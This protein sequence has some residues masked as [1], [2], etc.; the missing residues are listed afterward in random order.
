LEIKEVMMT[1]YYDVFI[2]SG[3]GLI[4]TYIIIYVLKRMM[5]KGAT[6]GLRG[7]AKKKAI[8]QTKS[9]FNFI[10][11][12]VGGLWAV[13]IAIMI[14]FHGWNIEEPHT[15]VE[16]LTK[17]DIKHIK[18]PTFKE[19]QEANVKVVAD[20]EQ[21]RQDHIDDQKQQARDEFDKFLE[22]SVKK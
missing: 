5:L 20:Q 1:I 15:S 21:Q 11:V 16:S 8:K 13:I 19:I 2:W 4:V 14:F 18:P 6:E 10:N 12:A 17:E 9:L 22:E 7:P 3:L